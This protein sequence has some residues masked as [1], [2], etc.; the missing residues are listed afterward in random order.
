MKSDGT[1]AG[2]AVES[3][4]MARDYRMGGA[5]IRGHHLQIEH[6]PPTQL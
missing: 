1:A 6:S 2:V 5:V 4:M 3:D